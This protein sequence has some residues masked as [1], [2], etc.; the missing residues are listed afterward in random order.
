MVDLGEVKEQLTHVLDPEIGINVVDLGLIYDIS[1]PRDGQVN[2]KM[3]L[4]TPDCPLHE[5]FLDA[6]EGAVAPVN[7]VEYVKVD[8]VF[9]P[10]WTPD[11]MNQD[12]RKQ[13]GIQ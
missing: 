11:R 12:V 13:L 10:P 1:E 7:G 6:V 9:D 4:T 5:G 3:T 2:I 8:V